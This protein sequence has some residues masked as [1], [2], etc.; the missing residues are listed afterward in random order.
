MSTRAPASGRAAI[1]ADHA[2]T[3]SPKP[4]EVV[5]AVVHALTMAGGSPGRGAHAG[6]AHVETILRTARERVAGLLGAG[7][8]DQV[9]FTLNATDALNL[10]IRG[11]VVARRRA[12]P[13]RPVHVVTTATAHNAV[14]RPLAALAN[15]PGQALTWTAVDVD[16]ASGLVAPETIASAV[17]PDTA[18]VVVEHATNTT[19]VLQPV[20]AIASSCRGR[21]VPLLVDAAQSA[22]HVPIDLDALGAD[23]LAA[24]GHKGLWGPLGVGVL[25]LRPGVEDRVDT[26]REGGTGTTWPGDTHPRHMPAK[27]ESGSPNVPGIAGLAAAARVLLDRGGDAIRAHDRA[28]CGA[29]LDAIAPAAASGGLRLLGPPEPTG[30]V[31]VFLLAVRGLPA[32]EAGAILESEFGVQVRAG[33]HCA[34]LAHRAFG[35]LE[36]G[37][38]VRVSFGHAS[39]ADEAAAAGAALAALAGTPTA[40]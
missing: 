11:T 15:R 3:S 40:V 31:P 27:L 4:P 6:A 25:C 32:A 36:S 16:P 23:L 9:A 17:G 37:G 28:L 20:E 39:T 33:L 12:A 22:G 35:T 30:R 19:G 10:A 34:P 29:F 21:G 26:V 8:P 2:S 38:A 14:L 13:D 24:P 18:L 1:Y 5:E 7:S